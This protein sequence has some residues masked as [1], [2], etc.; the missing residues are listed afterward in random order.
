MILTIKLLRLYGWKNCAPVRFL[1]SVFPDRFSHRNGQPQFYRVMVEPVTINVRFLA[2]DLGLPQEQVQTVVSLLDDGY[3][4]PFIAR[5]RK[6][7]TN[8]MDEENLRFIDEELQIQRTLCERK[9][10]ILK[11]IDSLGK[12]T[13]ELDKKIRDAKSLKRLEDLY[14]P[15]K[16]KKQTLASTA[17]ERG[18][19]PLA[20]EI[21]SGKLTQENLDA[22]AAEFVNEDKKVNSAADALLGAGHVI[23]EI[24]S[25]KIDVLQRSRDLIHRNGKIV[26]SKIE[27]KTAQ[28]KVGNPKN[29]TPKAAE[30]PKV[31][32][33]DVA[34][35][36][37]DPSDKAESLPTT[38]E[39]ESSAP[40]VQDDAKNAASDKTVEMPVV[41]V[42]NA[43]ES[44]ASKELPDVSQT[45]D[46][47]ESDSPKDDSSG[48]GGGDGTLNA[49]KEQLPENEVSDKST[50][51]ES[52]EP[53]STEPESVEPA[54]TG[55]PVGNAPTES[56]TSEPEKPTLAENP[57]IQ[58]ADV[59][60]VTEQFQQWKSAQEEQGI[61]TVTS[62]N[63]LKKKKRA[64][65]KKKKTEA[66]TR[67]RDHLEK[68]FAD[69]FNFSSG[70][71][72]MPAHRILAINRGERSK[73]LRVR[74]DADKE[75]IFESTQECCVPEN[76]PLT[77]F[78]SGCLKDALQ[79]LVVPSM[80]RELRT[81]LTEFAEKHSIRVFAKNLKNLLLQPPL[82]GKR[83]LALDPGFKNG[84]KLVPLDE[85]GNV[86]DFE[87]VFLV[88]NAERKEK[89]MLKIAEII[90]KYNISII[91][92][93]NGTG[94]REA[95]E[96]VSK[97][98][99]EQFADE[100]LYYIVVNEA[101]ASVYSASPAAQEE[102]PNYDVLLRGAVSIGRR[103]QDPLNEL[104]KI[105]P[106]SLGVGMYQHDVK[107]KLLRN[108]LTEVVESCVNFVGVD[109]NTATPAILRYVSGLNQLTAKRVYD[110][111]QE[112][113][114]FRSREDLKKVPGFGDVAFT[115]AAGFLKIRDGVNPLD[116]TWIHPESY[117]LAAK[118]LE[119]LGFTVEELRDPEKRNA[120][121]E[122]IRE[123][124]VGE[125][126]SKF[127]SELEAGLFTVRDILDN[128]MRPHRDSRDSM[129][130][131]IF[132]K[133]ILHVDDLQPGMELLGTVLNVVDFGAF[134]DIGL[135]ESGLV[136]V[137]Q[138]A[139]R[140]LRDAHDRVSVGDI[141]RV[142]VVEVEP[143]RKRISL[144]MLPPGTERTPR[145]DHRRDEGKGRQDGKPEGERDRPPREDRR[146]SRQ[147]QGR[148]DRP[149]RKDGDRRGRRDDGRRNDRN[150]D[151]DRG[152]K[153]YVAPPKEKVVKPI[154]EDMKKGKE[155]LRSFGDLAQLLGRVQV[156]DSA[157]EKKRKQEEAKKQRENEKKNNPP[158]TANESPA[159]PEI[160][161]ESS[162][163]PKTDDQ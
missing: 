141:V 101:G 91:A 49:P 94:C 118:I 53:K 86:L 114:P 163:A 126:A 57:S 59:Q 36:S 117:E 19:E 135:H 150:R 99:A 110:Y 132:R 127:S 5:Y 105:D 121:A 85:F 89:A 58:D 128:L 44:V 81:E 30:Q 147:Q 3:P 82:H 108:S 80:E 119:K 50:S 130:K 74:I 48:S 104:V 90:R 62:Q 98:I 13:P 69:Y 76:H 124:R 32:S 145:R 78:L 54:S 15:Y 61:P 111:R 40:V 156:P 133:G 134:I 157:E 112:H 37:V 29:K 34:L 122:K 20:L 66:K 25:E 83:V 60:A 68:Q 154:T 84:C 92:I 103:L 52:T 8:N 77:D 120:I 4:V 162:P 67:Q 144:T 136:H 31:A 95:E 115:H 39:F 17:R 159:V 63:T 123:G 47:P 102:F 1:K 125:L 96:C 155:P 21:L 12:L 160:P 79:R 109:L 97:M 148:D 152:P 24:F 113:G 146:D 33:S 23:A 43:T 71:R 149:P 131:P 35:S 51:P 16:P 10:A 139:D 64:D 142:W 138:M 28:E 70:V 140:Y 137:S 22:R 93:G 87:T 2:R 153:T 116:S 27:E 41:S 143:S 7:A 18:L 38:A 46:M 88:G 106:A 56:Q 45:G 26:T 14:L 11:T 55:E 151:R 75:K 161:E 72:N 6:D 42:E 107:G 158:A 65:A 73:I 100:E 129:P 9:Q